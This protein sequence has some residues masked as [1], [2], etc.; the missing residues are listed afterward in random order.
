MIINAS[1]FDQLLEAAGLWN[2]TY[3]STYNSTFNSTIGV[4]DNTPY[5]LEA[6]LATSVV[7]SLGRTNYYTSLAGKLIGDDDQWMSQLMPANGTAIG[8]GGNAFTLADQSPD[9]VTQFTLQVKAQ[10]YAYSPRG[11]TTILSI[12]I[13]LIYCALAFGHTFYMIRTGLSSSSWDT[14]SE[15][16]TLAMNSDRTNVLVNTGAGIETSTVFREMIYVKADGDRLQFVFNKLPQ[17]EEKVE[18]NAY[19]G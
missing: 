19:Y 16:T 14:I 17:G 6:L 5:A 3:G 9:T 4:V 8:Y 7:N 11:S 18:K 12:I 15:I 2:I 13:L 10:G 1:T